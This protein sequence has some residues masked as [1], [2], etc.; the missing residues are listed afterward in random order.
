MSTVSG[1]TPRPESISL[2]LRPCGCARRFGV[3]NPLGKRKARM[4][5]SVIICAPLRPARAMI[6]YSADVK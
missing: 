4:S 2:T 1:V 6:G 5:T 3:G